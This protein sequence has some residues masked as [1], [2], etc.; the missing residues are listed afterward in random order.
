MKI[1]LINQSF[2][3]D[4]VSTAQHAGDLARSLAS[5]GHKVTVVASRRG[6]DNTSAYFTR[7]EVWNGVR[8]IR[9]ACSGLGKGSRW[10]RIVDFATFVL[11]CFLQ[12]LLL[13]RFDVVVSMTSPPLISTLAALFVRLKGGRLVQWVMDLNPDEAIAAGWLEEGSLVARVL[14]LSLRYSLRTASQIVVLDRFMR[15]RI[16][17]KGIASDKLRL[18]PPWSHDGSVHYDSDGRRAFREEHGLVGKYV[19]M[20]SGNHSPC[21]PLTTLLMA[22]AELDQRTDIVFCFVGGGSEFPKVGRFAEDHRL[23]NIVCLPYQPAENLSGSLSAAD[24]H[25][26]VM[27]NDFR[28]IVHPCKVYNILTLGIPFLYIGPVPSHVTEML[29]K[30]AAGVWAR[31]V[32]QGDVDATVRHIVQSASISPQRFEEEAELARK[33]SQRCLVER[34][35]NILELDPAPTGG[36]Q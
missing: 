29:P 33:F 22:A 30:G 7:K 25:A 5:E 35:M 3:P 9:V 8:I 21:H 6:Y 11:S 17:K 1:L 16:I 20:Y 28:G 15:E 27:G 36:V 23:T 31:A 26:V 14:E 4:V 34:F 32:N 2:Y 12:I 18:I 13:P 24:L 19:I 10:R